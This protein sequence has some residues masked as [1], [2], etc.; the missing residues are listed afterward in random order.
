MTERFD[1]ANIEE[2]DDIVK[3]FSDFHDDYVAGIEI[4]FENYK[5]L[6]EDGE[7]IGIQN[8]DKTIILTVNTYPYKKQKRT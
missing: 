5:A 6:N 1:A 7:S 2:V 3:Y 4:K 8:A